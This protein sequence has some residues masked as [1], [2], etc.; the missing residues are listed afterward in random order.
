MAVVDDVDTAAAN[1]PTFLLCM[2]HTRSLCLLADESECVPDAVYTVD[3]V[4]L[5]RD[6]VVVVAVHGIVDSSR[7]VVRVGGR[8][9]DVG[10]GHR[11]GRIR[12]VIE[13]ETRRGQD[14]TNTRQTLGE[15]T[16]REFQGD[17]RQ[18]NTRQLI[19]IK[20]KKKYIYIYSCT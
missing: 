2:L 10:D 1:T 16:T 14:K 11:R 15:D 3:A 4:L 20:I 5:V 8:V 12:E 13:D 18:D 6:P 9:I 17:T 7:E 19:N